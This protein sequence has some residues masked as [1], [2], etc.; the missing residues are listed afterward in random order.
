ME[1]LLILSFILALS[2]LSNTEVVKNFKQQYFWLIAAIAY[3]AIFFMLVYK[4]FT[5]TKLLVFVVLVAGSIANFF[6]VR[7][8]KRNNDIPSI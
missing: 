8:K 2:I 5:L 4:N 1:Y 3:P 7:R 6:Y